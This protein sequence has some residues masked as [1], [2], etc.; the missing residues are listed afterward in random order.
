MA[1]KHA[2]MGLVTGAVLTAAV[3]MAPDGGHGQPRSHQWPKVRAEHLAVNPACRVCKSKSNVEVH[4]K[5][6]FH[7]HPELELDPSNLI[8]LCSNPNCKSH[9]TLGHLGDYQLSNPNVDEDAGLIGK[10]RE[11]ARK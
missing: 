8:T 10:R 2:A 6:P 3:M 1:I 9:L 7:L 5:Q 4:H 11:D